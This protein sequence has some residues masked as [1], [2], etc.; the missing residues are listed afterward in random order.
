[1]GRATSALGDFLLQVPVVVYYPAAVVEAA[2]TYSS[3]A[4]AGR[5]CSMG[6]TVG[7]HTVVVVL[8]TAP[9]AVVEVVAV[10]EVSSELPAVV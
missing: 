6:S 3:W 8:G 7:S 1:M 5:G 9:A 10:V 2:G 4:S